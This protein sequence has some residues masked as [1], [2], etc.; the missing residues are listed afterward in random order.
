MRLIKPAMLAATGLVLLSTAGADAADLSAYRAPLPAATAYSWTGLYVGANVGYGW[1]TSRYEADFVGLGST[2]QS[3]AMDGFIGGVQ[4][5][6]NYQMG[7]W[8][9]G[10]ESDIQFSAQKGGSTFPGAFGGAAITTDEKLLWFGTSRT[11]LGFL[12]TPA[13]LVYG[14]AGVAYGQVKDEATV[15]AP[16]PGVFTASFTDVKAGWTAGAGIET[17]FGGGWSAKLEY[18][19]M[20]LGETEHTFG[21][22][23]LGTVRTETRST[24]DN[25]LRLGMNYRWG[26]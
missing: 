8:V 11:R 15:D 2:S 16:G 22:I 1:G 7:A 14:T 24:T 3:E 23:A 10:F 18:L 9:L 12:A 20:D 25:I 17:A 21:T 6:Y 13:I 5:G 26:G 19:Y 4:S